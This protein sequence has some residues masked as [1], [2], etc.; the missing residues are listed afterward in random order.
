MGK[1]KKAPP[2]YKLTRDGRSPYQGYEW[3][4]PSRSEPGEWHEVTGDLVP[5]RNAFHLTSDPK[6][7]WRNG[8]EV[9]RVETEGE[10]VCVRGDEWC[11][12]KVRLVKRL[13]PSDLD[14]LNVGISRSWR[15]SYRAERAIRKRIPDGESPVVR[16]L[17]IVNDHTGTS[18]N[19]SGENLANTCMRKAIELVVEARMEFGPDDVKTIAGMY[20]GIASEWTYANFVRSGNLSA[21][22][23]WEKQ[24]GLTPWLWQGQ[25]LYPGAGLPW[26]GRA[27]KITTFASDR[28]VACSYRKIR[29]SENG[30]DHESK[31]DK[32]F[33][34]T[35]EKLSEVDRQWTVGAA[36]REDVEAVAKAL[37]EVG[38]GIDK[39]L[40]ALWSAEERA[41][42]RAWAVFKETDY[43]KARVKPPEKPACVARDHAITVADEKAWEA[44]TAARWAKPYNERGDYPTRKPAPEI[45]AAMAAVQAWHEAMF[46][47][48][49]ADY[50]R[51]SARK[52]A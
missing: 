14:A 50:L 3:T 42:A 37:T 4:L 31:V 40:I 27:C 46:V 19:K 25:R 38:A 8:L 18:G 16:I 10:T 17:R 32:R 2:L 47:G 51:R 11:A 49:P 52:A 21:C 12:R 33:T 22:K 5:H 30:A 15:T 23:S 39:Y 20:D 7:H 29:Y 26:A 9:W 35:R 1:T 45:A 28:L 44:L 36:V 6:E 24:A 41:D 48:V 34:I 43:G 13:S